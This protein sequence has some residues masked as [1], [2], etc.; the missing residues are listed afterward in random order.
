MRHI[1]LGVFFISSLFQQKLFS[2][3]QEA[4]R[5]YAHKVIVDSVLQTKIYTYLKV[6]E[7]IKEKDSLQWLALPLIQPKVGDVYYFD[8]GMQMGEF[9][10][11]E[12]N[13]TFSS[14]LFLASLGTTPEI[15]DLNIVPSPVKDTVTQNDTP[16]VLHTVVVKEVI[17]TS[18]YSYLKVI[19]GD[20]TEWLAIVKIPAKAGETYT[21]DDAAPMKNFTSKELK[22]T[23][24]E[25][26][27]VA[28]LT[29]VTDSDKK[30]LT[31]NNKS[32]SER[33]NL[34]KK[35]PVKID[36]TIE[37]LYENKNYY[38]DKTVVIKG[39]ITK[40]T[41]N[42]MGKTW[43]HIE[44]GT[45]FSGKYDLTATTEDEI[46]VGDNVSIEGI[47]SIDKDFGSGYFFEVIME[48]VTIQN[49]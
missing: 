45:S 47:I 42:I 18:G 41:P 6:K 13:R 20:K 22:R 7:Q 38:S 40:R 11:R 15:S 10:S 34:Q 2:Q 4:T 25:V 44:D 17:Q 16:I 48:N 37:K 30:K 12:L 5:Y 23:F 19:E 1:I 3:N 8:S 46:K 31:T 39:K 49:K 24:E 35:S 14:I 32:S 27:F 9:Q 29:L 33:N 21:Y 26:I 28:K 43:I 36:A